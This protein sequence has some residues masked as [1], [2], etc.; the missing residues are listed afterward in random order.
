MQETLCIHD[1]WCIQVEPGIWAHAADDETCTPAEPLPLMVP[2]VCSECSEPAQDVPPTEWLVP[3]P[4]P[5]WSHL[6]GTPLCPVV[7][8]NGYEPAQPEEVF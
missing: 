4:R 3:A 5:R 1:A 8:P 7:G 6:D 2:L